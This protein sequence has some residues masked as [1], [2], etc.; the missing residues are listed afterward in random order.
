MCMR[1]GDVLLFAPGVTFAMLD[2]KNQRQ[3]VSMFEARVD[4]FYLAP[5]RALDDHPE[6][7]F[8][9]GLLCCT[10]IDFLARYSRSER[11]DEGRFAGWLCAHVLGADEGAQVIAQRLYREFR[12]GLVHEGRVKNGGQFSHDYRDQL[13]LFEEDVAIVNPTLLTAA[14]RAGLRRDCENLHAN[15]RGYERFAD[16]LRREFRRELELSQQ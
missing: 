13:I 2:L 3:T 9:C 7:A 12:H 6:W 10:A 4:G 16:Q 5:A 11:D 1:I 15:P 14:V 8:A